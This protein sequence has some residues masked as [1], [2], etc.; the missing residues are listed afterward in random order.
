MATSICSLFSNTSSVKIDK[1]KWSY[2]YT[3]PSYIIDVLGANTTTVSSFAYAFNNWAVSSFPKFDTSN[4]TEF[5]GIFQS[6]TALKALPDFDYSKAK[7]VSYM[8]HGCDNVES[9]IL[10]T[11]NKL[12]NTP[13][14]TSHYWT[15][16]S[17]GVSSQTGSAELAQIP[18]DWK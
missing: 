15:F 8:F 18:S 16:R 13:S 5:N 1:S 11:Y 2:L 17:C 3:W 10:D 9:G 4:A 6:S 14:I 7:N 12:S